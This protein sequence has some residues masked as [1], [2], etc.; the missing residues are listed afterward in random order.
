[1]SAKFPQHLTS[2]RNPFGKNPRA[3]RGSHGHPRAAAKASAVADAA[4]VVAAAEV[5][6]DVSKP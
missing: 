1:M 5:D 3:L 4:V 6:E 2:K